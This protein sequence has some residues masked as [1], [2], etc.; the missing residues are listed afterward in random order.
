MND[1][2]KFNKNILSQQPAVIWFT[3][4][5]GSGKTT[6]SKELEKILIQDGYLV[7]VLD[8]DDLRKNLNKGLGFSMNERFENIRRAAEV[9]RLFAETGVISVCCFISPSEEMREMAREII[10]REHFFLVYLDCPIEICEQRDVKGLYTRVRA[11]KIDQFS[12]ISQAY[13]PPQNPDL[14]LQTSKLDV[15]ECSKLIYQ[16]I[17][18]LIEISNSEK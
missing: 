2:G 5:S 11:G 17:K 3:G 13:E 10:G 1:P 18:P 8:G 7:R 14:I 4:L 6:L 15:H 9:A 12:G 16:K